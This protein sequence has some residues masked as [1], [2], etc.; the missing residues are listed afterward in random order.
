[1]MEPDG[2]GIYNWTRTTSLRD[3]GPSW[4]P[5]GTWIAFEAQPHF[6]YTAQGSAIDIYLKRFDGSDLTNLTNA[7]ARN[8]DGN[9][10]PIVWSPDARQIAFVTARHGTPRIQTVRLPSPVLVDRDPRTGG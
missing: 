2:S 1:M 6:A 10:G 8:L 4:S 3:S 9:E 7:Q 5:D